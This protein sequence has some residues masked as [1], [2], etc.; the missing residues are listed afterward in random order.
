MIQLICSAVFLAMQAFQLDIVRFYLFHCRYYLSQYAFYMFQQTRNPDAEIIMVFI[1]ASVGV[2]NL[3]IYCYF[4]KSATESYA[5]MTDY[6][7]ESNWY[8]HPNKLQKYFILM[9]ANTQTPVF[10][11]GFNIAVLDLGTFAKVF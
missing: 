1:N 3:F 5:K 2:L 11:H 10:Y 8:E 9:I 4:G 6:L 7:V